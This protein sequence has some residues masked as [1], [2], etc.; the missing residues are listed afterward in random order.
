MLRIAT[1]TLFALLPVV[2]QAQTLRTTPQLRQASPALPSAPPVQRPADFVVAL[3]NSEPITNNEVLARLLKAEQLI[4]RNGGAMPPRA[5]LARQMLDGLIDERAQLQL[6]RESGLKVDEPTLDIAVE[7]IARQNG[8]DVAELRRR[9][10]ADG[11]DYAQFR[12]DLRDKVLLQKLREREVEPRVRITDQDVDQFIRDQRD[13]TDVS[14]LEL[15]LAQVLVA[16]PENATPEQVA[17]LQA[18]AQRAWERARAGEDFGA[19]AR[20]L[21]D[22]QNRT[23]G[24]QFGLRSADRLPPLFVEATKNVRTG[25]IAAIVRSGAGFHVLK[26]IEKRQAGLPSVQVVQ[27]RVRHILLRPGPQLSESAALARLAEWRKRIEAKEADFAALAREFSQ[28]GSAREG[29][30][31]GWANPGQF[32]PEFEEVVIGLAPGQIA[33]P[34]VSR[35]GVHLIQVLER[36]EATLSEREQRDMARNLVREKKLDEAFSLWAQ[37][38]RGRAYVEIRQPP[39]Q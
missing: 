34:V 5:E 17:T 12:A 22:G 21:S 33:P 16:V 20:E 39:A 30:D 24:G 25:G 3:V 8:V 4:S 6:A 2:V 28:D 36:R 18:K 13:S 19:L 26:V 11:M 35:F 32:V 27:T 31:L 37:E 29:G 1:L 23:T 38:V 9:V 10:Q 15:N 14:A 7:S